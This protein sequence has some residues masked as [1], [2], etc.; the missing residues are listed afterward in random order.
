[1][2]EID[3]VTDD[4]DRFLKERLSWRGPRSEIIS[5]ECAKRRTKRSKETA[6]QWPKTSAQTNGSHHGRMNRRARWDH[7][8]VRKRVG[9]KRHLRAI[10]W[11]FREDMIGFERICYGK[12]ARN[13]ARCTEQM[14]VD[15]NEST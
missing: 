10:S 6:N 5:K 8:V 9:G 12:E 13:I 3:L 1:M 7:T 4:G 2:T 14:S 15:K 11:K